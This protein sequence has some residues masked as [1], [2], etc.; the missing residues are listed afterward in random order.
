M[1]GIR[2]YGQRRLC[3]ACG[4]DLLNIVLAAG[5]ETSNPQIVTQVTDRT[6]PGA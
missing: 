6:K 5:D 4:V 3:D 1:P 2:L